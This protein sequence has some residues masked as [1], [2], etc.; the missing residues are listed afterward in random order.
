M[1]KIRVFSSYGFKDIKFKKTLRNSS[2]KFVDF[3]MNSRTL[4]LK[5]V[6]FDRISE[7]YYNFKSE[8]QRPPVQNSRIF[9]WFQGS[10]KIVNFDRIS[11]RH[12]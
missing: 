12:G 5:I 6:E 2:Q 11:P 1:F 3:L 8:N 9:K 10:L 4:N 7:R